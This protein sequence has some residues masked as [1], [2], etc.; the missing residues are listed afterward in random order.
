MKQWIWLKPMGN[1][2]FYPPAKTGGNSKLEAILN[3]HWLQP[4]GL[5]L[6]SIGFSQKN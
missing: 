6:K 5:K 1:E 4:V 3:C 2:N